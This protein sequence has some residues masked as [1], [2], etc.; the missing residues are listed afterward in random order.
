MTHS[1]IGA[2]A[3]LLLLAMLLFA[4]PLAGCGVDSDTVE[5]VDDA[6][7][8]LQ[9]VDRAGTWG[10]LM[11]GLDALAEQDGY[12]A[13]LFWGSGDLDAAGELSASPGGM[14]TIL[15]AQDGD[16]AMRFQ[17]ITR[18]DT[19]FY[20]SPAPSTD[21]DTRQIYQLNDDGY[22]CPT[23]TE[24]QLFEAG[25]P[26][27]FVFYGVRGMITE[28]LSVAELD[29]DSTLLDRD[30]DHYVLESRLAEAL[31]ILERTNNTALRERIATT[32]QVALTGT[33][34][35]DDET[36]GLLFFE[37]RYN[38]DT[39]SRG[40]VFVFEVTQWGDVPNIVFDGDFPN[41]E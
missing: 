1:H 39:R 14:I 18:S 12:T 17:F 10:Y 25:I 29:D 27:I 33:F 37:G 2:R 19:F 22:T 4:L 11:D 36:G 40:K 35:L 8:L 38:N 9:D 31:D 20:R 13:T 32:D 23:D 7:K 6:V 41:C 24:K 30:A 16:G 21:T 34:D 3:W 26:S 5:K 15:V 28:T